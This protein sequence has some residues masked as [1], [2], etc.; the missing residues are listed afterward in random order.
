MVAKREIRGFTLIELIIVVAILGAIATM[1]VP[2][3]KDMLIATRVRTAASDL[4]QAVVLARSEAIKRAA[5]VDV[6]PSGGDWNNGWS[7]QVGGVTLDNHE[8]PSSTTVAA[9]TSGNITFR[10]DGRVSTNVRSL[11]LYTTAASS[12]IQARC[13]VLDASGRA[14]IRTDTDGNYSNG[15]N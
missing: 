6:V 3:L 12:T 14:S 7:I 15:C 2:S 11:T 10:L 5:S 4:F 9:N 8:A 13:V 1:A